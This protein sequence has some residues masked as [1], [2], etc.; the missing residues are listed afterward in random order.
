MQVFYFILANI[1]QISNAYI[2]SFYQH[3]CFQINV[4]IIRYL[5]YIFVTGTRWN[6]SFQLNS[7]DST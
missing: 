4:I 6:Q 7:F 5:R 1:K 2:I 3:L